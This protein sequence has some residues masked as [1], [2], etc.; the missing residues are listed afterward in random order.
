MNVKTIKGID[1][2]TWMKFKVLAAK[3]RLT[4]GKL[5]GDMIGSYDKYADETWHKILNSG[6][7]LSDREAEDLEKDVNKIRKA[8]WFKT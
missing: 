3:K 7:I 8:K 2:E 5:L 4:M 1:E 6:K